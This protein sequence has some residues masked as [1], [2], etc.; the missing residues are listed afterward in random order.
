MIRLGRG[1]MIL[2]GAA[3]ECADACRRKKS[4]TLRIEQVTFS[5]YCKFKL[6]NHSN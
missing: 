3:Y 4:L 2:I 5:N 6:Y 1:V